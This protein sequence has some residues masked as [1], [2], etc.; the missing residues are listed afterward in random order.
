MTG[1]GL[2]SVFLAGQNLE[3]VQ[4]YLVTIQLKLPRKLELTFIQEKCT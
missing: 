4:L 1:V 2:G 3:S